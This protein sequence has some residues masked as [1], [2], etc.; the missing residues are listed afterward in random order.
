LRHRA[1]LAANRQASSYR[2]TARREPPSPRDKT[3]LAKKWR[4]L[5][6][7][8]DFNTQAT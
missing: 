5:R 8:V 4:K 2:A 6:I 1:L 3:C 7:S